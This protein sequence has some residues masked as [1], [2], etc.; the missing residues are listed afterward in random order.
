[1]SLSSHEREPQ[2]DLPRRKN[3]NAKQM[4]FAIHYKALKSA[5]RSANWKAGI[6]ERSL[7]VRDIR[8]TKKSMRGGVNL[9]R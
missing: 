7:K 9:S 2:G 1:M 8:R 6:G 3:I 5:R 4:A